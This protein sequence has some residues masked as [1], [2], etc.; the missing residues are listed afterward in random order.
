MMNTMIP[1]KRTGWIAWG[2][3][4]ALLSCAQNPPN[5]QT[6]MTTGRT[7]PQET[8]SSAGTDT[9]VLGA[10]CFWCVEAV[11]SELKGVK[12]VMP[13]YTGGSMKNPDYKSVCTG[14]T[15]HAEVAEIVYDRTVVTLPEILE[16]F[17]QT[18]DPTTL[19]RQGADVGTQYRSA[20]FYRNAE[21][22]DTAEHYKAELDKSGA[23]PRPIVTEI[24]P[25]TT[26][27]PAENYH[28]DYY[29]NNPEQG[30]CQMVIRPKLEKFRKA[31]AS[32]VK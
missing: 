4:F 8:G 16:V 25:L 14:E 2:T 24:A 9:I 3:T 10:G 7:S 21:Q 18:H 31:F 15:G 5:E 28:R 27:Y 6:T 32:K 17:W 12:S 11:F 26:F 20:I 29:A 23:F 22:R 30:Y 1:P 19:N 13:G